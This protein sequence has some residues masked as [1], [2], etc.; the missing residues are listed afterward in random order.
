MVGKQIRA[1]KYLLYSRLL[2][3]LERPLLGTH[4]CCRLTGRFSPRRAGH[5]VARSGPFRRRSRS[6]GVGKVVRLLAFCTRA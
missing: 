6:V 2:L 3:S 4:F 5:L 1:A